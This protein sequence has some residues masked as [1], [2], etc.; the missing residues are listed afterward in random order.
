MHALRAP[1][2]FDGSAFLLD[3]VTV[4]V[5]D[6]LILGV[7]SFGYDVPHDC[8]VT[9]YDGT[10]LPGLIDAH[11]H[12]VS[13]ASLG[14]LERAGTAA[15]NELDRTITESLAT[16]AAAGVTTVRDLGDVRYRTLAFRDR[17]GDGMPRIVA[18]GPPLTVPAG[19]CHYLGGVVDGPEAIRRMIADHVEQ[20]VDVVKVMA[21]GGMLTVGT[22][23]AGTQF[24]AADLRILVESA[25]EAGLA[26]LA[27]AHSLSGIE[28]A[29]AA[30]VDGLEHFTGITDT[31]VALPDDLLDRVAA[32]GLPVDPTMGN[33]ESVIAKIPEPPPQIVALMERLGL[34]FASFFAQRLV[35]VA[36]MR[37]RGVR[38][39]SGVDAGAGPPKRHGNA[40]R[41]VADLIAAGYPV[42][43]ALAASTSSAAEA[44]GVGDL[45][46]RLRP[47]LAADLLVVDGDPRTD[48]ESLSRPLEVFVRGQRVVSAAAG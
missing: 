47:G 17:L 3:G 13:D 7:E 27:H 1:I 5:D 9:S 22:D 34:D 4:L 26:V 46:G 37:E 32:A 44:C 20:G 31:G 15:D 25:H 48:P 8:P 40:W 11:V 36:R 21:S 19:H 35:D 18:A 38:I 30:G 28:H 42:P 14:S 2:A 10:L 24:S 41:T 29:L 16:Q 43:D 45:T 6:G 39:V 33:D 12:L 23:L